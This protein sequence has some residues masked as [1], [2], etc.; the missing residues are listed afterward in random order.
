MLASDPA[1]CCCT[2]IHHQAPRP[3]GNPVDRAERWAATAPFGHTGQRDG[4]VGQLRGDRAVA[5]EM[6][7]GFPAPQRV[8]DIHARRGARSGADPHNGICRTQIW[9]LAGAPGSQPSAAIC[10]PQL[11]CSSSASETATSS[12][13]WP[14]QLARHRLVAVAVSRP[15]N[16]DVC[17]QDRRRTSVTSC[18]N[19]V[20]RQSV[21]GGPTSAT[22]PY[23]AHRDTRAACATMLTGAVTGGA[24]QPWSP[25]SQAAGARAVARHQRLSDDLRPSAS[26]RP[27]ACPA[28]TWRRYRHRSRSAAKAPDLASRAAIR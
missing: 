8:I 23:L 16:V 13:R 15:C 25:L 5:V 17:S 7:R 19:P 1:R 3:I 26:G 4:P 6:H 22:A 9:P 14:N 27:G 24:G 28:G 18:R 10:L 2:D 20:D 21:G 12:L 11:L